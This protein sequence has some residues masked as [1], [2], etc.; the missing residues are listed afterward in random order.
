MKKE[1][2]DNKEVTFKDSDMARGDVHWIGEIP[3]DWKISKLRYVTVKIGSGVTP[4][5][6]AEVYKTSGVPL[7]RSQNV[8]FEGL[9]LSD[10]AYIDPEIHDSMKGSKVVSG[11]VLFN[12][13]GASIGRC[14]YVNDSLGEANVNQHVCIIRPNEKVDTK[15]LNFSLS[16]EIGQA[17]VKLANTGSGREGLNFENLKNFTI[18][19]PSIKTQ[20]SIASFLDEKTA[21]IDELIEKKKKMIELLEEQRQATIN[22]AVTKGLDPNVPMKDSGIEWIGEIPEDWEIL[23]L[24]HRISEIRIGP[25]GSALKLEDLVENGY[26]VYGQENVIKE[27]WTLGKRFLSDKKFEEMKQYSVRPGDI[28]ITMMGTTG[29][30]KIVPEAIEEG[31]IDSHLIRLRL[32]DEMNPSLISLIINDSHMIKSQLDTLS[33]GSIMSGLN[34]KIIKSLLIPT[35]SRDIQDKIYYYLVDFLDDY[36][37]ERERLEQIIDKLREYKSALIFNAVTGKIQVD[38]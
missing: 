33:R 30:S 1:R 16:S 26:R 27:D 28:L 20:K 2:M 38:G 3:G 23:S 37:N 25:F 11:D 19:L 15:F 22:Q 29:K 31:I 10:V 9:S 24:K 32:N 18:P 13:T 8:H 12:I 36:I 7:L 21:L 35:P 4:K 14:F 34:S 6:G 17:Q 5:G